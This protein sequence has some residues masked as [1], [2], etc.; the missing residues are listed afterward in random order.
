MEFKAI[1]DEMERVD[2]EIARAELL[3]AEHL[4]TR[5]ECDAEVGTEG[6]RKM[7]AFVYHVLG[8]YVSN[9]VRHR[10]LPPPPRSG[11]IFVLHHSRKSKVCNSV[12]K[13]F[14]L[15]MTEHFFFPAK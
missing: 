4:V 10:L 5:L 11:E 14:S 8:S 7:N 13:F 6:V 2:R 3:A 1:P 9:T 12:I 15:K